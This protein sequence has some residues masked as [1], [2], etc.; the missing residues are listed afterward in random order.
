MNL[1]LR[2]CLAN[3]PLLHDNHRRIDDLEQA[4]AEL[5]ARCST[6]TPEKPRLT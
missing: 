1:W 4:L 3:V 6:C 2:P 5:E